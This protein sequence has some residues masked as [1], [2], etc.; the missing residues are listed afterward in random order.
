MSFQMATRKT[1]VLGHHA[2]RI[3][4]VRRR[5]DDKT[6]PMNRRSAHFIGRQRD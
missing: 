6:R 2:A 3:H 5:Q 1:L 4:L